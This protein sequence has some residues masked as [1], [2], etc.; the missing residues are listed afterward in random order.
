MVVFERLTWLIYFDISNTL[1]LNIV[2][3]KRSFETLPDVVI[4]DILRGVYRT[5]PNIYDG[6]FGKKVYS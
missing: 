1:S 4:K 3:E 5:L 2:F 6:A